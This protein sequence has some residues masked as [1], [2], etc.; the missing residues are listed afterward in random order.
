MDAAAGASDPLYYA[1][2]ASR[3][4]RGRCQRSN[5]WLAAFPESYLDR[6]EA[7]QPV[8]APY[9]TLHKLLQGLLDQHTTGRDPQALGIALRLARYVQGRVRD[10]IDRRSLEHHFRSLNLEFG[11]MNDVL[12]RL[13]QEASKAETTKEA[14]T[15]QEA[16]GL[17][18]R[19][20]AS[21]FDR[22]CLLGPLAAGHDL[23]THLHVRSPTA[24]RLQLHRQQRIA[25]KHHQQRIASNTSP[26]TLQQHFASPGA[27]PPSARR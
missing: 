21:L 24:T 6:V 20:T 18:L 7:L 1:L 11:G 12:W 3:A 22:P 25:S 19:S 5:G 13:S 15:T 9:Y 14:E 8:W 27:S 16:A 26:A 10:I 4:L 17:T 2:L 23:L